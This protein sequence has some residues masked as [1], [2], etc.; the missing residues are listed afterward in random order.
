MDAVEPYK[1]TLDRQRRDA[2]QIFKKA[3]YEVY[4]SNLIKNQL[5]F[6]D[7]RLHVESVSM[8]VEDDTKVWVF[9]IGKAVAEMAQAV[10]EKL[11][12]FIYDG[13]IIAPYGENVNLNRIQLFEGSHPLP[14]KNSLGSALEMVSVM[15]EVEPGDVVLFLL[16]GG[17]SSLAC[18]P[19]GNLELPEVRRTY[20]ALLNSGA[21]I[22]E[23]NTVRRHI[24]DL[25]GGNLARMLPECTVL[26]LVISDV[27]GNTIQDI[28]SGPMVADSTTFKDALDV[29]ERYDLFDHIPREVIRHL[30]KGHDNQLM[31][32][33]K[34]DEEIEAT[35]FSQNLATSKRVAEAAGRGASA[36]GYHTVVVNPEYT[37]ETRI[38]ARQIAGRAISI[39]SRDKPVKKP[40]A[41][42]Y[43]GESYLNVTGSGKGGRNQELALSFA[44]AVEGQH[45]ITLLSAG[46]DGIDGPT[47]AAGAICNSETALTARDYGYDPEHFLKNNDSNTF[48]SKMDTLV[49]TG[50][51]GTNVMDLQIV[52]I[53]K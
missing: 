22:E 33:L 31:D 24:S 30:Q 40:A 49:V 36:K 19:A 28:G 37:G 2:H 25:K 6:G 4:P 51:T 12:S 15:E 18:I 17:A 16:S 47:D 53:D 38:I 9:G 29:I 43:H 44:L 1:L 34:P 14:D 50:P 39:L 8:E 48:F 5:Q 20:K 46:T 52:L 32:T 45:C 10:E 26:Q 41:L 3:L 7:G 35:V 11:G 13:V 21:S 27:P 23:T 42:I